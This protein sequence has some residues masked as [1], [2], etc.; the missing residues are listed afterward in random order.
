M[1]TKQNYFLP[2][3]DV[4]CWINLQLWPFC[5]LIERK[6]GWLFPSNTKSHFFSAVLSLS[7]WERREWFS[8]QAHCPSAF[9]GVWKSINSSNQS[10]LCWWCSHFLKSSFSAMTPSLE[11]FKTRL[12]VALGS[13][14][15]WL[16]T[17]HIAG[18]LK[19]D[20]H[21]GSFQPRRFYDSMAWGQQCGS[22]ALITE[23]ELEGHSMARPWVAST[24]L[25]W[26]YG[27]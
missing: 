16:A 1:K 8:P 6:I 23:E 27:L 7:L 25:P 12:D 26:L 2:G 19:R 15:W 20:D 21:C 9:H 24:E 17:L 3:S 18:G 13:L 10:S 14:V 4:D 11:A 5:S 22:D